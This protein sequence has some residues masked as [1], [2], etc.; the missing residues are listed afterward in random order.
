MSRYGKIMK[1]IH[2]SL[3]MGV[4]SVDRLTVMGL[5]LLTLAGAFYFTTVRPEQMRLETRRQEAA[6]VSQQAAQTVAEAPKTPADKIA[7][8]YGSFPPS[9]LLPDLLD[10][11]FAAAQAQAVVLEQ[12]EYKVMKDT[13]G[14]L[15]Q[16]QV[17][18]P[19]KGTYPQIRKFVAAALAAVPTL[20]LESIK[21]ERKKVGDT[22][23]DTRIKFVV[24]L[25]KTS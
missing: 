7:A 23:L 9:N 3:A 20:S 16:Y 24:Y 8:F 18:F 25:G 15:T 10:K 12:G 22:R 17:T 14:A 2:E 13:R 21:F 6:Q 5:G 1:R 4:A 11:V 19:V